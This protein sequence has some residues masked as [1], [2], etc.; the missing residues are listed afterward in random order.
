[1]RYLLKICMSGIL[2]FL[3]YIAANAEP[4]AEHNATRNL[5]DTLKEIRERGNW[6][7]FRS[8]FLLNHTQFKSE[9]EAFDALLERGEIV[10]CPESGAMLLAGVKNGTIGT[11]SWGACRPG[12]NL[13]FLDGKPALS[14]FCGN[15]VKE[16]KGIDLPPITPR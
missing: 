8:G 15:L 2:C 4:Y 5:L 10:S 16:T 13:I 1:M 3:L 12:E 14:L 7:S 6:E 11:Y 9:K